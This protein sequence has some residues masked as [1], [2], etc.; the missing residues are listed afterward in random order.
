MDF[1]I[2]VD[3]LSDGAIAELLTMHL[4]EMQKYSPAE[5]IHALDMDKLRDKS[6]TFWSAKSNGKLAGCG[7]LKS[8]TDN[9]GEIKSMKTH[10]AFLRQGVAQR[11]LSAI[12]ESATTRGYKFLYLE[13]GSHDAFLPAIAMYEKHGFRECGPFGDYQLDPHS[14]FFM[15]SL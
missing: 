5:S 10:P 12:I 15:N 4:R 2:E 14:R 11:I 8:L 3:D 13:T 6:M 1:S 9:S 7:A